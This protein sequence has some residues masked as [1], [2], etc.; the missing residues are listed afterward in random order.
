[1]NYSIGVWAHAQVP[2]GVVYRW[3]ADGGQNG[4][5]FVLL[6]TSTPA[7]RP[8]DGNGDVIGDLVLDADSGK[9]TGTAAG[10]DRAAFSRTAAAILKSFLKTG[11]VPQTAHAYFG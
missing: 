11:Q 10:I 9:M 1:V 3:E 5:G 2:H 6:E 7:V 4:T 8:C